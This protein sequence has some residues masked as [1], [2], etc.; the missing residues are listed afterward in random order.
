MRDDD[1]RCPRFV[2][3]PPIVSC[4]VI[5][6]HKHRVSSLG[7]KSRAL[8]HFLVPAFTLP[9]PLFALVLVSVIHTHEGGGCH[10]KR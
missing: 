1:V 3:L 9:T 6:L 8:F 7:E 4:E 5:L 10:R 2:H